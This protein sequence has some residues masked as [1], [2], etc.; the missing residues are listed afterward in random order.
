MD[1]RLATLI[2]CLSAAL[3]GG[4]SARAQ[5]LSLPAEY[6]VLE[7]RP[8]EIA[9]HG[10]EAEATVEITATMRWGDQAYRSQAQ[11][12]SDASGRVRLSVDAPT[13]G[14]YTGVD[15]FGL[16]WSAAP[17]TGTD[18][19]SLV[20]GEV[21]IAWRSG[22]AAGTGRMRWVRSTGDLV[23][24]EA[25]APGLNG[26]LFAP[27]DAMRRPVL[28]VLGG[29]EGGIAFARARAERL[30]AEG[31]PALAVAYFAPSW[32][33]M[34]DV[35]PHFEHIPVELFERARAWL[36]HRPEANT[37]AVA[38]LGASKGAEFALVAASRY[39]W[40]KAVIAYVPSD[41]VWQ[42]FAGADMSTGAGSSWSEN[43]HDLP[44]V[45]LLDWPAQGPYTDVHRRSEA[46][47]GLE[48]VRASI[49][50]EHSQ[51]AILLLAAERDEVWPSADMTR[52][53]QTR[54]KRL[55]YSPPVEAVIYPDA[56][57]ELTGTGV[58][59]EPSDAGALGSSPAG[60][61]RAKADAFARAIGFLREQLPPMDAPERAVVRNVAFWAPPFDRPPRRRDVILQNGAISA[62]VQ[63]SRA[64]IRSGD[65]VIDGVGRTLVPGLWDMHVHALAK[66]ENSVRSILPR[67]LSWGVVGVR[68]MGSPPGAF[69][70]LSGRLRAGH[71]LPT[72]IAPGPLLDGPRRPWQST[73][74]LPLENAEAARAAVERLVDEGVDFLKVYASL[75]AEQF[76]I[77]SREA[78]R[79]GM[80]FAGHV[81]RAVSL[82]KATTAGM[83]SVEHASLDLLRDCL[84][85][86]AQVDRD[87]LDGW[88]KEGWAG[89]FSIWSKSY[90]ARDRHAC[91]ATYR[92]LAGHGVRFTPTLFNETRDRTTIDAAALAELRGRDLAACEAELAAIMSAPDPVRTQAYD[93]VRALVL[94]VSMQGVP[95]LSGSDA[96]AVCVPH[97]L[98]AHRELQAL[99]RLGLP[100]AVLL[101]IATVD[102]RKFARLSPPVFRSGARVDFI[103]VDGEP[104]KQLRD[105]EQVVAVAK[106]GL[107]LRGIALRSYR[108]W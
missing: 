75:T 101:R 31:W 25:R 43:G 39:A 86:S 4:G 76:E 93:D 82:D 47:A 69:E 10:A 102:S 58:R 36:A 20:H 103:L 7:G 100:P 35:T 50:V 64:K 14:S 3:L 80:T 78:L 106:G 68:D 52:R 9:V 29:S 71:G 45:P 70:A 49:P 18:L 107:W 26:W 62:I 19:P 8:I 87:L 12:Q 77:I 42:G 66:G 16:F 88:I 2:V 41:V 55:P 34:D 91:N 6:E 37:D 46:S 74:A 95:L 104:H 27:K 84:P 57:H 60:R 59:P 105:L 56:G 48:I 94:D 72:V 85:D 17:V 32:A 65:L 81:P 51:A 11:F 38:V 67:Y 53:L 98:A 1:L 73:S 97:G 89:R 33:P 54:L 15:P 63:P 23:T 22:D 92:L 90:A 40:I 13:S 108:V 96:G 99:E 28:L 61:A 21:E 24:V 44:F 30:A 79:R 83:G 5:S